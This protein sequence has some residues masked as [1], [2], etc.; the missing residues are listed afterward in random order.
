MTA[1]RVI[2]AVTLLWLA[3]GCVRRREQITVMPDGSGWATVIV[4][5]DPEEVL[6]GDA[7]PSDALGWTTAERRRV[8]QKEGDEK[9]VRVAVRRLAVGETMPPSYAGP[10]TKLAHVA[11]RFPTEMVVQRR[12]EGTYYHFR[13]EYAPRRAAQIDYHRKQVMESDEIKAIGQKPPAEMSEAE[14]A[15]LASAFIRFESARMGEFVDLA[16]LSLTPPPSADVW[17]TARNRVMEVY[18]KPDLVQQ[19]TSIVQSYGGQETVAL[20]QRLRKQT[21]EA[22]RS[23]LQN[24]HLSRDAVDSFMDAWDRVRLEFEVT[25]DLG[26]EEFEVH[27]T[28]PGRIVAH[29]AD[30]APET[31]TL[32]T[33]ADEV[34]DE[35]CED[36]AERVR[37]FAG[38]MRGT[39]KEPAYERVSWIFKGKAV[40]DRN[41]VLLATSFVPR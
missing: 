19:V 40:Y 5:G 4:E 34:R 9:L 25:E 29:N 32:A 33:D 39:D 14:L 1:R 11:L 24:S 8:A 31:A 38:P 13:R 17:A 37:E 30:S 27:L 2:L 35:G 36:H 41:V 15:T 23:S 21:T 20:E 6:T 26:D 7:M 3:V 18:Q 16:A 22:L 10:D 28:L 12:D